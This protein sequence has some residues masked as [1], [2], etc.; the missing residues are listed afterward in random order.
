MHFKQ[1]ARAAL[2][3][4]PQSTRPTYPF[5]RGYSPPRASRLLSPAF[6]LRSALRA[7]LRGA[8]AKRYGDG[9]LYIAFIGGL[10]VAACVFVPFLPRLA[11]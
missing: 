5:A 3:P 7:R 6:R 10:I 11:L 4:R 2:E 9:E 1:D 8:T